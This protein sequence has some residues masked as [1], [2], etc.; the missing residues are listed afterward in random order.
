[1]KPTAPENF[2]GDAATDRLDPTWKA[3]VDLIDP[4]RRSSTLFNHSSFDLLFKIESFVWRP[5]NWVLLQDALLFYCTLYTDCPG[6]RA[7]AA[8]RR[9]SFA[10]ITW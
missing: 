8:A 2:V 10:Q 5:S 7:D 6:G 4:T 3:Q 1:M 9:V